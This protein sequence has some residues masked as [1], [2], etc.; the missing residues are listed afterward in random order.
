MSI[1][2]PKVIVALD[3]A[4]SATVRQFVKK[5]DPGSCRLKVGK[6]LFTATGPQLV[7]QLCN[8]GFDVFLDLKFHDIPNTVRKAVLSASRL[9]IWMVNVHASG[10]SD[11]LM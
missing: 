3:M 5:L 10:G 11:M 4:D 2:D 1:T 7:E 8:Q 9:G 6:E